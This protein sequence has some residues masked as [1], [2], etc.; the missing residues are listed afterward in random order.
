MMGESKCFPHTSTS[1]N[2]ERKSKKQSHQ[3][4]APQEMKE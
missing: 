1:V 2:V 4:I 3:H